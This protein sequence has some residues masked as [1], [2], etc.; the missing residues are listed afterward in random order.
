MKYLLP[1]C[2]S[3]KNTAYT[4]LSDLL[5]F[6]SGKSGIIKSLIINPEF[7]AVAT[8]TITNWSINRVPAVFCNSSSKIIPSNE[9]DGS[10]N[11]NFVIFRSAFLAVTNPHT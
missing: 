6:W 7:L 1:I 3:D 8:L 4:S 9:P 5:I 11:T 2:K 10:S